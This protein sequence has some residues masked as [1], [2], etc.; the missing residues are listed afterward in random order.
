[1]L[2]RIGQGARGLHR[3]VKELEPWGILL[4]VFG[5]GFTIWTFQVER[6]DREEDRINRAIGQFADGI[7]RIDAW[8]VLRRSNVDLRSLRAPNAFLPDA[9]LS[10]T[11]LSDAIM[12][13]VENDCVELSVTAQA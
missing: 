12:F 1:M 7:G 3:L 5:F 8:Q 6:A 4:A 2:H 9:D 13:G 11:N 10:G